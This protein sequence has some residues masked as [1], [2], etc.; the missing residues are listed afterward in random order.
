MIEFR[1]ILEIVAGLL[2]LGG[3]GFCLIAAIGVARFPDLY[4]R[5]H[6]ATKAGTLGAGLVFLAVALLGFELG[7][8][9]RALAA[10]LFL[11]L[12]APVGAHLL[13]RAAYASGV[14][15]W[16]QSVHDDLE[17][18]YNFV[19]E[20]LEGLPHDDSEASS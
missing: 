16:P 20:T 11:F 6:A 2:V 18:R 10:I 14:K 3:A 15:M 9:L 8:V 19:N 12:T 5:M 4:V 17:G 7:V 13:A 1:V